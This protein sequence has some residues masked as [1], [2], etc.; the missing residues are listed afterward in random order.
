MSLHHN[1]SKNSKN[2]GGVLITLFFFTGSCSDPLTLGGGIVESNPTTVEYVD[3]IKVP[4]KSI[5]VDSVSTYGPSLSEQLSI[6][7]LGAYQDNLFGKNYSSLYLEPR[8]DYAPDFTEGELEE[9]FFLLPF[10]ASNPWVGDSAATFEVEVFQ[11]VEQLDRTQTYYSNLSPA[12][13]QVPIGSSTVQYSPDSL[14]LL[15]YSSGEADTSFYPHIK[16]PLTA[17]FGQQIMQFDASTYDS[18]A[19]FLESLNGIVVKPKSTNGSTLLGFD[20]ST[21]RSGIYLYYRTQDTIINRYQLRVNDFSVKAVKYE[22]DYESALIGEAINE[23]LDTLLF[24]EGMS[25]TDIEL[26]FSFAQSFENAVINKAEIQL[27]V[28]NHPDNDTSIFEYPQRLVLSTEE[29][30]ELLPIQDIQI[31]STNLDAFFGGVFVPGEE[32]KP[33]SYNMNVTSHVQSVANGL[34]NTK[35]ILSIFPKRESA[36][37][38]LFYS[39]SHPKYGIKLRVAYTQF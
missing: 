3:D 34:G 10:H 39:A 29:N 11:L 7:F 38:G 30:G 5:T 28:A 36:E 16:I 22:N 17:A 18:D 20:L 14:P 23:N 12:Y 1:L 26:D 32:G 31:G 4:A 24:A 35:V 9:I 6:Y 27:F 37:R 13:N 15:S 21:G 19:T 8:P 33:G 2:W 25:G